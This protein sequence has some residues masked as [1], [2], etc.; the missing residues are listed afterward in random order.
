MLPHMIIYHRQH[1]RD[2]NML[3]KSLVPFRAQTTLVRLPIVEAR[4]LLVH[5]HQTMELLS[6]RIQE[7][8]SVQDQRKSA[9]HSV[10]PEV[11]RS[12]SIGR[13]TAH[14]SRERGSPLA[15]RS[16]Q[17]RTAASPRARRFRQASLI[18]FPA[19]V[20]WFSTR[21]PERSDHGLRDRRRHDAGRFAEIP[22]RN[23]SAVRCVKRL[24]CARSSR[25]NERNRCRSSAVPPDVRWRGPQGVHP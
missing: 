20:R 3:G 12:S 9:L 17:S 19:E 21:R 11:S 13:N 25:R 22:L 4:G 24:D 18:R 5:L 1:E 23:R 16:E 14:C 6:P 7:E 15:T 2:D 10:E 8:L